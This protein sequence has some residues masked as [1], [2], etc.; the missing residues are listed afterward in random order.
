MDIPILRGVLGRCI[1]A[2]AESFQTTYS[3]LGFVLK[4]TSR[5]SIGG[6]CLTAVHIDKQRFRGVKCELQTLDVQNNAPVGV[7]NTK[8][9]FILAESI[10]FIS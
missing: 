6:Y 2:L 8:L 9:G 4:E 7:S 1:D 3:A 10:C 5:F